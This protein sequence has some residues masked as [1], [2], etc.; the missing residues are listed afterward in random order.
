[1]IHFK[2][3][4]FSS[5]ISL[6]FL[7]LQF[8]IFVILIRLVEQ[9]F[10]LAFGQLFA[11]T[12]ILNLSISWPTT[13]Y[14]W[15]SWL[16][17]KPSR[18]ANLSLFYSFRSSLFAFPI[19]FFLFHLRSTPFNP[20]TASSRF[21]LCVRPCLFLKSPWTGS[22]SHSHL[23]QS[24]SLSENIT[25]IKVPSWKQNWNPFLNTQYEIFI[26][27]VKTERFVP[28]SKK[29][30]RRIQIR[31]VLLCIKQFR[32][33]SPPCFLSFQFQNDLFKWQLPTLFFDVERGNLIREP[34]VW[35]CH[36]TAGGQVR[37]WLVCRF[38]SCFF[39]SKGSGVFFGPW[40]TT[41]YPAQYMY[42]FSLILPYR[43]SRVRYQSIFRRFFT[44]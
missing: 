30:K 13:R 3:S 1:M 24:V 35:G 36:K 12:P 41:W 20:L 37:L 39:S 15:S 2:F 7:N 5:L 22:I 10:F 26:N 33:V 27:H 28:E 44:R 32:E 25:I 31:I 14:S 9:F 21:P 40:L 42:T 6:H 34:C 19:L 23:L 29:I 8:L 16:F 43:S 17:L 38:F 4:H 18:N 11:L